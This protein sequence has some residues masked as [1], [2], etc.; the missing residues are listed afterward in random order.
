M[1]DDKWDQK[2]FED[3]VVG[4]EDTFTLVAEVCQKLKCRTV[5]DV[6]GGIGILNRFL[7]KDTQHTVIDLSPKSKQFGE[8][9]FPD[10][11]FITGAIDQA[12]GMYDAVV[13]LSLVEHLKDYRPFLASAWNKAGKVVCISF[14]NGLDQ[15]EKIVQKLRAYW[16]NKFSF[17]RL[18]LWIKEKLDPL[19]LSL[20]EAKVDRPYSPE[21][22]LVLK[23]GIKNEG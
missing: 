4:R 2:W 7:T 20:E 23:K 11:T 10:V 19:W 14:R 22:I 6:G 9:L 13:A 1:F 3:R 5:L 8:A 12:P 17:P 21:L 18:V 16:D 15:N